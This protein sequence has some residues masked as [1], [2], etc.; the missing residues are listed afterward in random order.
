[1]NKETEMDKGS[2]ID[3]FASLAILVAL[4]ALTVRYFA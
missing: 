4:A 1:M 3:F 2:A